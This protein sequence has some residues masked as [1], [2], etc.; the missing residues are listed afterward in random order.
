MIVVIMV[1]IQQDIAAARE[2]LYFI[3]ATIFMRIEG[4]KKIFTGSLSL[5]I[6]NKPSSKRH[7][8]SLLFIPN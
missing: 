8:I 5:Q 2:K 6:I 1:T 4:R 7:I 3:D